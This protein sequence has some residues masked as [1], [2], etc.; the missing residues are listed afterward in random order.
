MLPKD[1]SHGRIRNSGPFSSISR[2]EPDSG[3]V[4]YQWQCA[5]ARAKIRQTIRHSCKDDFEET[6]PLVM[7]T[8]LLMYFW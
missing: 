2:P 4:E 3:F 1:S 6:R 8:V 7:V 5:L